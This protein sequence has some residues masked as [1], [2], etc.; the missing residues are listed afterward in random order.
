MTVHPS[1]RGLWLGRR[2]GIR[3]G[4]SRAT[5]ACRADTRAAGTGG[6]CSAELRKSHRTRRQSTDH[7]HHLQAC[8]CVEMPAIC[9]HRRSGGSCTQ[10]V[11]DGDLPTATLQLTDQK[12]TNIFPLVGVGHIPYTTTDSPKPPFPG[13]TLQPGQA[14]SPRHAVFPQSRQIPSHRGDNSTGIPA[15]TKSRIC[16]PMWPRWRR[17]EARFSLFSA[18][19]AIGC[20]QR[21]MSKRTKAPG[22]GAKRGNT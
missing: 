22:V 6:R 15:P 17:G 21:S 2:V 16:G 12:L 19:L 4:S 11:R 13:P 8:R 7:Q 3:K 5:E 20:V 1:L 10:Q 14:K 9:T 18:V